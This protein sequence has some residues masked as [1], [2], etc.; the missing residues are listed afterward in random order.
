MFLATS[1]L[2]LIGRHNT[3]RKMR[4]ER[5]LDFKPLFLPIAINPY[6]KVEHFLMGKQKPK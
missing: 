4:V 1:V 3:H 5:I 6:F 2:F